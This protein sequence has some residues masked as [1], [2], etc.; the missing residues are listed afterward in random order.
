MNGHQPPTPNDETARGRGSQGRTITRDKRYCQYFYSK[1]VRIRQSRNYARRH[2]HERRPTMAQG[3]HTRIMIAPGIW[4]EG[5]ALIAEVRIGSTRDG[6][7]A[8]ARER[9]ALG[10]NVDTIKAWQHRAKSDLLLTSPTKYARGTLAGDIPIYLATL[11][12]GDY[13][14]ESGQIFAH[15]I[16]CP[17]GAR[18]RAE[19]TRL[20]VMAQIARWLDAG[21]AVNTCNKRLSRLRKFFQGLDGVTSPNPTDAIKFMREPE[22]EP[23]DIAPRLVNLILASM[24]DLGRAERFGTRPTVSH[25]KLRLTVMAWTGLPPATLHRMRARDLDLA[26]ARIYIRPRRKGKGAPGAWVSVLP[27]A[28][29][30]L[31][32]YVAAGLVGGP[33]W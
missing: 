8:R 30:A 24:P 31:R 3:Q 7:Q 14:T 33:R 32:A 1:L 9:F 6:S 19:I 15:W 16:A 22:S 28:V 4:R 25:T 5:T 13:R 29:D 27:P 26:H 2:P 12:D 20:D 17:L 11:P 21:A 10:T 23:R 18:P